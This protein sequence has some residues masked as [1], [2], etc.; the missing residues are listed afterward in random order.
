MDF[1]FGIGLLSV[2]AVYG[3][4]SQCLR[5]HYRHPGSNPGCITPGYD[6]V[7]HRAAHNW[8][9][10]IQVWPVYYD[11]STVGLYSHDKQPQQYIV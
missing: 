9:S 7:S 8:P 11:T 5:R 3:T 10:V 1:V 2:A 6:W 4:A